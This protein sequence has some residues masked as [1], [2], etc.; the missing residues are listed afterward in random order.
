MFPLQCTVSLNE[1]SRLYLYGTR[2]LDRQTGKQKLLDRRTGGQTDA[3]DVINIAGIKKNY[4]K[5]YVCLLSDPVSAV[6]CCLYQPIGSRPLSDGT[7]QYYP[8][9][10]RD[11]SATVTCN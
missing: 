6:K 8:R 9:K 7:Y 3:V 1:V 11:F 5:T 10:A 4:I 2:K